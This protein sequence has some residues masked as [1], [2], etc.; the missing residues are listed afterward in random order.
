MNLD[1]SPSDL[2]FRAEVRAFFERDY[3]RYILM[4]AAGGQTLTKQDL[5]ASERAL[6]MKGWLA[7]SWPVEYGGT[8]WS[9]AQR[10][11]FDEEMQRAGA[12]LVVPMGLL[13]LGPILCKFG[14][15]E[16]KTRWLPDILSGRTFWAQGYSE[17]EAGSDLAS[18]RT[19]AARSGEEYVVNGEKI[20]TSQAHF[21]DWIFC[22]VR[23]ED[24]PRKQDGIT[25]LCIDMQTEGVEVHPI[26]TID[27]AHVLNRVI[28]KD[29]RVPIE[30]RIGEEGKA[31]SYSRA[32]LAYERTSYARLGLK[33]RDLQA[34]ATRLDDNEDADD[35]QRQRRR[36]AETQ[37]AYL[38]LE[39]TLFRA[40]A[41]LAAGQAPGDEASLLKIMA[42]ETSQA[43]TEH[44]LDQAGLAA[45]PFV[46]DRTEAN[47]I[48]GI[49]G[50]DPFGTIASAAY[51]AARA[52]TIYGGSTEV[53]K[54]IIARQLG[55]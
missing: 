29:V 5:L 34:L 14:S 26:P 24:A 40:L 2:A 33:R 8:G 36:L 16:Q 49:G 43:I 9:V 21:A 52:E 39:A 55:L 19:R 7:P 25:L 44:R 42:T 1:F 6:H 28:F 27:G 20:W 50:R 11:I 23:T 15:E 38:A 31:W 30:N 17:P 45:A 41:P 51:F 35:V 48:E 13:Y 37:I 32:L 53:Q 18:L 47:W 4:K 12:P 3:P 46:Y 10:F 22:L 54:N